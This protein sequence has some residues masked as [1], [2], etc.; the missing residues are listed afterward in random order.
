M[1]SKS[2]P[3]LLLLLL[4]AAIVTDPADAFNLN[5]LKKPIDIIKRIINFRKTVERVK[6][7]SDPQMFKDR[8]GNYLSL[9][10]SMSLKDRVSQILDLQ[11]TS[12]VGQELPLIAPL[13]DDNLLAAKFLGALDVP[14]VDFTI[15]TGTPKPMSKTTTERRSA[16]W[17]Q[18]YDQTISEMIRPTRM[19]A[20]GYFYFGNQDYT[21]I[22]AYLCQ[23]DPFFASALTVSGDNDEYFEISALG[24]H[25]Y[26]KVMRTMQDRITPKN[27]SV[28]FNKDMTLNQITDFSSGQ[29]VIVAENELNYYASGVAYTMYYY[30]QCIHALI[31]V[32]HYFMTL[33]MSMATKHNKAL[34]AWANLYDTNIVLKYVEVALVLY[35]SNLEIAERGNNP[36][37]KI[38]G[39]GTE[40]DFTL[41]GSRH[42]MDGP[43][44]DILYD[45]GSF[46]TAD[47]FTKK[48]LLQDIYATAKNPEEVM[49]AGKILTEFKKHLANVDPF[50]EALSDAFKEYNADD[51]EIAEKEMAEFMSEIGDGVSTIDSISSFVALMSCTGM[52]H[53]STLGFTRLTIM[54][55]VMRWMNPDSDV[56]TAGDADFITQTMGTMAGM[57]PGRHVFTNATL[58]GT[59]W[60]TSA[61]PSNVRDVLDTYSQ[62]ALDLKVAYQEELENRDDFREYGWTLTDHCPDGFDGKQH[63][64]A[65]YI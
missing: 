39:K 56:W 12:L 16:E 45:W 4:S 32:L 47:E 23:S 14:M 34:N 52:M 3:A 1:L 57:S 46:K 6:H 27:F 7:I 17:L 20:E 10:K 18:I 61:I 36:G 59:E 13:V 19:P 30:V 49:K 29:G 11:V 41:G 48:F 42:V 9:P 2:T 26:A 50:A 44:R 55:E 24:D 58:D 21:K 64:V 38:T 65:T 8:K 37:K 33:G 15:I 25:K 22:L 62:K 60:D 51:V 40:K 31:H 54:P 43:M 28:R 53:G 5:F 63:T 35:D